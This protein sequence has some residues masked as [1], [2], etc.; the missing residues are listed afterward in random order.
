MSTLNQQSPLFQTAMAFHGHKCPAMPMGLR[1]AVAAMQALGVERAKNQELKVIAET[2]KGHA[3]GCF[4]DGVMS[5]TGCTYGKANIEKRYWNKLAF[6]LIETATGRAVR[7]S[8]KP[9]VIEAGLNGPFVAQ[10]KRGVQPQD[11][12][13]A[14]VEP[15]VDKVLARPAEELLQVSKVFQIEVKKTAPVFDAVRCAKCGES[16]FVSK[17][18]LTPDGLTVCLPCSGYS[19]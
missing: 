12:D 11:V 6:T 17:A 15:L 18:R 19:D 5:A 8:V 4:L 3:M 7:V 2:G 1:A 14:I 16:V 9:E 10:R 13:P